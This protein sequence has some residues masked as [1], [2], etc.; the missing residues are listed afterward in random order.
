MFG[1]STHAVD[2][3]HLRGFFDPELIAT[4]IIGL[5][6]CST[7]FS[8][9]AAIRTRPWRSGESFLP[10]LAFY[11]GNIGNLFFIM[12]LLFLV[13]VQMTA[14]TINPFIYFRF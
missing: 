10:R 6:G 4:G 9:I 5:L 2:W 3:V 1:T 13:T 7:F 12:I 8:E 11:T 14:G